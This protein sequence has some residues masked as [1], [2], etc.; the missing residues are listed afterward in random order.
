MSGFVPGLYKSCAKSR[1]P[2]SG[3]EQTVGF[4]L[5][6]QGCVPRDQR[7]FS[8]GQTLKI[9]ESRHYPNLATAEPKLQGDLR[10]P[11]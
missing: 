7:I 6:D 10:A 11:S 4:L 5:M 3:R 1:I 2:C 9:L 8:V